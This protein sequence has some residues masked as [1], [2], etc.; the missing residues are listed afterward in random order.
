MSTSSPD[1]HPDHLRV[2]VAL[3][4][5]SYEILI[6]TERPESLS[7]FT[8]QSLDRGWAGRSC[9]RALIV[10]DTHLASQTAPVV[11]ALA[12]IG[13][14]A[15]TAVLPAGES[16]KSLDRAAELYSR[17][18]TMAAD[19]HTLVVAFGGG[20]I[21]DLAGFV[22]ATYARGL[23]LLMIPTSLLAQVDSSV[24]GKVG[25]NLP[26]AKNMVGAFHQPTG[27]WIETRLLDTLP[28]REYR[29]GIA[30]IVKYGVILDL[31]FFE[32]LEQMADELLT[33]EAGA[34][35]RVVARSCELK[36]QIVTRDER[37]ETGLRAVLNFGHTIGHA[38][39]AL[40]GYDGSLLHGEAVAIG[41][42][43][44]SRLAEQVGWIDSSVTRRIEGLLRRFDLPTT[45]PETKLET[46]WPAMARDKK[47]RSGKIRFVLPRRLGHVELTDVPS[48]AE[49]R[50]ALA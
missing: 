27:V 35:R 6:V 21:G 14:E 46:L 36:A 43:A 39:E 7:G 31:E 28:E 20:V 49:L 41:M 5:R 8:R 40:G 33:R 16:S 4:P 10:T 29:S 42:V 25:V 50:A 19:R 47:N 38:V 15:E 11:A 1:R 37:E 12:A 44:E 13:V 24:G 18:A 34:I 30:E 32:Q 2:H 9:R 48:E 45:L 23:P 17:L 26:S 3:G 22:A